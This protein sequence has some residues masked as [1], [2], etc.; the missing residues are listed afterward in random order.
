MFFYANQNNAYYMGS[1]YERAEPSPYLG[2]QVHVGYHVIQEFE[3][4]LA[5]I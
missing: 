3:H 1:P 4:V 2:R 5:S